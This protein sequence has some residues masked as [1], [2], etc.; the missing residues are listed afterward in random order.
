MHIHNE[1][2]ALRGGF[3]VAFDVLILQRW[4]TGGGTIEHLA[5]MV[6]DLCLL[7]IL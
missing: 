2:T 4:K 6:G 1:S 5:H 3:V 7:L